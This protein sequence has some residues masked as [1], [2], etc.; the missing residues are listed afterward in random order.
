[1]S[2]R[3]LPTSE[4]SLSLLTDSGPLVALADKEDVNH[5]RTLEL[6]KNL[7]K[8]P[9]WTVWPCLTEAVYLLGREG[10]YPAQSQLLAFLQAGAIRLWN[11]NEAQALQ[12]QERLVELMATYRDIPCD[13]ADAVLVA[14]AEVLNVRRIFT[15]D[16]HFY[17]YR[18][19]AGEAFE[20]L[21][22]PRKPASKG[23]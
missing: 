7:P 16:G 17:A 6:L 3:E 11:P 19:A 13:F 2:H 5:T 22:G 23:Q 1:M 12:M 20:V 8:E 21:L 14:S 15:I 4:L 9:L 18:T 10:G